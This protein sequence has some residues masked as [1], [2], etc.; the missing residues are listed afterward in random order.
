MIH[1][2]GR[3]IC[4]VISVESVWDIVVDELTEGGQGVKGLK[5]LEAK[6]FAA[7]HTI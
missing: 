4:S 2:A 6:C 1:A 3:Y 7:T 5:E